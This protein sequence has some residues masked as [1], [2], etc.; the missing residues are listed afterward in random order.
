MTDP[1]RLAPQSDEARPT[2]IDDAT[3]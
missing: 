2:R 3:V 1:L